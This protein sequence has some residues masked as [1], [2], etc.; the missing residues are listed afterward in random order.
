MLRV[1]G[2]VGDVLDDGYD[3]EA[4]PMFYIPFAGMPRRRMSYVVRAAG[5]PAALAEGLRAAVARI[6][7]DVP[8]GDLGLLSGMMAE[9]AARPRAASM[10]GLTFAM[11]ALLVATAGVYGVLS[12]AVQARTREIG[13]R[14]ALGAT[15]GELVAM[16]MRRS[17]GLIA[18]GLALGTLG[19][20]ASGRFLSSL[21]FGV[22]SWDPVSLIGSAV[23]LAAAALLA[24]W[25]PARRAVA[26]DPKEALRSE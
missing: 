23:V 2:V 9:T 5:E 12:Y 15:G 7:P 24:S 13:I 20:L 19:A 16:V 11:I 3:A 1:V 6:D 14:L 18:L 4:D 17:T 25:V 8:A 22:R 26:I 21:L 10:I